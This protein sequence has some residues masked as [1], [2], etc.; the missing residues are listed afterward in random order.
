MEAAAPIEAGVMPAAP[1]RSSVDPPLGPQHL[2]A[3]PERLTP[4]SL[5]R[6]VPESRFF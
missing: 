4:R 6:Q 3:S 2:R 1:P 5:F